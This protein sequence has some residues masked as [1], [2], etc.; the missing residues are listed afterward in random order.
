MK[1]N[2]YFVFVL[3]ALLIAARFA[4]VQATNSAP[5]GELMPQNIPTEPMPPVLEPVPLYMPMLTYTLPP[6][7]VEVAGHDVTLSPL[8]TTTVD[9]AVFTENASEVQIGD[10]TAPVGADGI[11]NV[12]FDAVPNETYSVSVNGQ[13]MPQCN[14]S[15]AETPS[16]WVGIH[17]DP[18]AWVGTQS[19]LEADGVVNLF[20]EETTEL[21][22]SSDLLTEPAE[23]NGR[24]TFIQHYAGPGLEIYSG[25]IRP[26]NLGFQHFFQLV[27]ET[28]AGEILRVRNLGHIVSPENL[29]D[30][31][32]D[33]G[34]GT[35][36][37]VWAGSEV[38]ELPGYT[39]EFKVTQ[40]HNGIHQAALV[41]I[42]GDNS[43]WIFTRET[44]GGGAFI[45]ARLDGRII[46]DDVDDVGGVFGQLLRGEDPTLDPWVVGVVDGEMPGELTPAVEE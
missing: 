27:L 32:V 3:F 12:S 5:D 26:R 29:G 8:G 6:E 35:E 19:W 44:N 22:V 2:W 10:V 28:P 17:G 30:L 37:Y 41:T 14:F 11:A 20:T 31:T 24:W 36:E 40:T 42:L 1:R 23:A 7:C 13:P 39:V 45:S 4:P 46:A 25:L 38:V 9:V 18:Y 43:Q 16:Q 34:P 21:V 15:F 33:T